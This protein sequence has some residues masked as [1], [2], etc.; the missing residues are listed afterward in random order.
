VT[1]RNCTRPGR[2]ADGVD[3]AS[4][5]VGGAVAENGG[6]VAGE[7]GVGEE[8][9]AVGCEGVS[10]AVERHLKSTFSLG[11]GG[12]NKLGGGRMRTRSSVEDHHRTL[13]SNQ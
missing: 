4:E 7:E 11:K 3:L 12:G 1:V 10:G 8:D 6:A 5:E 9:R 13:N 2:R